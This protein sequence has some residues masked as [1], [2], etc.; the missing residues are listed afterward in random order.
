[1]VGRQVAGIGLRD[2]PEIS[3]FATLG[4]VTHGQAHRQNGSEGISMEL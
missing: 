1:M 4:K 2:I 3:G